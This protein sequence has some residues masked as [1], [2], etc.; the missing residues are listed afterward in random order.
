M[1]RERLSVPKGDG[2]SPHPPET[3]AIERERPSLDREDGQPDVS[4]RKTEKEKGR[5]NTDEGRRGWQADP[6]DSFGAQSQGLK[7]G[8]DSPRAPDEG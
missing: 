7:R 5:W 1:E 8:G 3:R 4:E 2:G 6:W